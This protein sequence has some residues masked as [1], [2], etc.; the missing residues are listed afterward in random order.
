MSKIPNIS[1][2]TDTSKRN[3]AVWKQAWGM[4]RPCITVLLFARQKWRYP[5]IFG[6][7]TSRLQ[8]QLTPAWMFLG[9][10]K[11]CRTWCRERD[12]ARAKCKLK[13]A[14]RKEIKAWP[15]WDFEFQIES[16]I[17]GLDSI[18]RKQAWHS[19]VGP[20]KQSHAVNVRPQL[21]ADSRFCR[22]IAR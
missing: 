3:K 19:S 5:S 21:C 17:G 12:N 20:S 13:T 14:D 8:A 11:A 1:K 18:K 15:H 22:V 4:R 2:T 16:K 9:R 6:K 10:R 7:D